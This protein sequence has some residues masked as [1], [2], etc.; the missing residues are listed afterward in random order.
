MTVAVIAG[1]TAF[2]LESHATILYS[3]ITCPPGI[4]QTFT[5]GTVQPSVADEFPATDVNAVG[6]SGNC[7]RGITVRPP[8]RSGFLAYVYPLF[9]Q[10]VK[11]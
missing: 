7:V 6:A 2:P 8:E 11:L 10:T 1:T 9:A 3:V 5:S 4:L